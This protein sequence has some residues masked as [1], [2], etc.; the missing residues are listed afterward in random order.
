MKIYHVKTKEDYDALMVEME[1]D[2]Y[3]WRSG[4][5]PTSYDKWFHHREQTVVSLDGAI[6]YA[7]LEFYKKY[8]PDIPI[9]E[10]KAKDNFVTAESFSLSNAIEQNEGDIEAYCK[11]INDL[12][13]TYISKNK[14]YGNSFE[15]SLD[16]F[17]EI[18]GIVRIGD[19]FNRIKSLSK[20]EEVNVKDES[21]IDTLL[22]MANY[23]IMQAKWLMKEG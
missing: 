5:K 12:K 21:K 9:I 2:G 8:F 3:K 18:A 6:G 4:S 23:C 19:K 17:G 11:I 16:E 15:E 1:R 7:S 14:D 22:D 20:T 13:Q 10:Y